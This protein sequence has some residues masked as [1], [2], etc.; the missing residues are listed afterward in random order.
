MVSAG[1]QITS[2]LLN[3]GHGSSEETTNPDFTMTHKKKSVS[4]LH[5]LL[6]LLSLLRW[7]QSPDWSLWRDEYGIIIRKVL[8]WRSLHL[9]S[10]CRRTGCVRLELVVFGLFLGTESRKENKLLFGF[11]QKNG[12]VAVEEQPPVKVSA[13][14][15]VLFILLVEVVYLW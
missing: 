3:G 9:G 8:L 14:E 11:R 6:Y 12:L 4:L 10:V 15:V 13:L 5:Y 7:F 2:Q 1:G